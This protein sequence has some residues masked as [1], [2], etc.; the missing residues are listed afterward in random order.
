MT[1]AFVGLFLVLLAGY[2]LAVH[3]S[4]SATSS[5]QK[6]LLIAILV[7]P[8]FFSGLVFSTLIKGSEGSAGGNGL[9]SDGRDAG[10][11]AG[12]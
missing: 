6:L 9:Q 3:G 5:P 4:V 7:G 12:I 8:L 11:R 2:A 10:R 1:W